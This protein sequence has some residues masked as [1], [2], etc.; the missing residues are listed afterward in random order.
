MIR[1][2]TSATVFLSFLLLLFTTGDACVPLA[3][4]HLEGAR[5]I[6]LDGVFHSVDKP[7]EWYGAEEVVDSWLGPVV[8]ELRPPNGSSNLARN[9]P[10]QLVSL[11]DDLRRQFVRS[12]K[13]AIR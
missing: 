10:E 6:T 3:Y 7:Q 2:P 13:Q 9:L 11:F 8:D 1:V 12:Q 5:Q 4:A